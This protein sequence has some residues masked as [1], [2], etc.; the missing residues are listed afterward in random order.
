MSSRRLRRQ[1]SSPSEFSIYQPIALGIDEDACPCA[2]TL[3]YRNILLAGEPGSG[4]SGGLN[5]LVAHAALS[6]DCQLWLMDGKRVE[7]GL[8]RDSAERF[9]GPDL[10]K[11]IT[12]LTELQAE[13]DARYAFLDSARRRK[14]EA[15]DRMTAIMLVIDEVAYYSATTGDKKQRDTFSMLLRD[16]V[17][18]GR[19]AGII[20]VA[21]TQRPS[22]D[23]IP[24]SLRDLFGYRLAFRCTTDSSSDIVLGHG[25][26]SRGYDAST[27]EPGEAG[28]GWLLAEG[29]IPRRI[30]CAY[31]TDS[32]IHTITGTTGRAA[33]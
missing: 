1:P 3:M 25:W 26:A 17:A 13:M 4:K 8:W 11:A 24:T 10:D 14:I 28:V 23:I 15:G 29:G 22:S 31:L 21:A 19:A 32:D 5:N 33:S 7:L 12:A 2:V 30:R 27:I 18:R 20:V 9:I 6:A 16:V